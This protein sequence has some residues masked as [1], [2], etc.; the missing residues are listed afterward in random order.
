MS[1]ISDSFLRQGPSQFAV[2][3]QRILNIW[4]ISANLSA[5]PAARHM[6]CK[7]LL[8]SASWWH[9]GGYPK[10]FFEGAKHDEASSLCWLCGKSGGIYVGRLGSGT[11]R[12]PTER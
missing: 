2:V 10:C 6:S 4:I 9:G 1:R 11:V 12:D 8:T 3:R 5:M 7:K